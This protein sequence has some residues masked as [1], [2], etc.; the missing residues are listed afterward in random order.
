MKDIDV[1]TR[2][3]TNATLISHSEKN[4]YVCKPNIFFMSTK[5]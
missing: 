3:V 2:D 5:K 1:I 4:I